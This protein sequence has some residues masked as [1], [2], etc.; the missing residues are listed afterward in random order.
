MFMWI[1]LI[2]SEK[3]LFLNNDILRF[4]V[5]MNLGETLSNPVQSQESM[6]LGEGGDKG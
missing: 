4:P 5:D 2:T 6:V 1:W 3:I